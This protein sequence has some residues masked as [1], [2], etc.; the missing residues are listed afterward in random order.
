M[1]ALYFRMNDSALTLFHP[2]S[3]YDSCYSGKKHL[4]I[5][6]VPVAPPPFQYPTKKISGRVDILFGQE[7][8]HIFT[9]SRCRRDWKSDSVNLEDSAWVVSGGTKLLIDG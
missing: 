8:P 4:N 3:Y 5:V 7:T 9:T 2:V 6:L 1:E